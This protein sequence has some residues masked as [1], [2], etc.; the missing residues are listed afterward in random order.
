M[1]QP[2]RPAKVSGCPRL[3]EGLFLTSEVSC[4]GDIDRRDVYDRLDASARLSRTWGDCYGYLLVATGRAELMVDPIV[5]V[6]D[7]AA[8]LPVIEEAGG[9]FADFLAVV[10]HDGS[11][12]HGEEGGGYRASDSHADTAPFLQAGEADFVVVL[13]IA[14]RAVEAAGGEG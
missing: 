11:A 7:T 2:P 10:E 3:C 12:A 4:F 14:K 9:R 1:G 8:L 6:W 13:G 5:S